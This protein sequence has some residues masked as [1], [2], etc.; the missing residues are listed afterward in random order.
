LEYTHLTWQTISQGLFTFTF[1][2]K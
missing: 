1:I 2:L